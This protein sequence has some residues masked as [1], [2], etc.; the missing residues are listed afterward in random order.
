MISQATETDSHQKMDVDVGDVTVTAMSDGSISEPKA[1]VSEMQAE[2]CAEV[3]DGDATPRVWPDPRLADNHQMVSAIT[4]E[5]L[6]DPGDLDGML[7]SAVDRATYDIEMD[8]A[9]IMDGPVA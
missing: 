7:A 8:L 2:D 6:P 3:V 1:G 5:Q 9:G 4:H